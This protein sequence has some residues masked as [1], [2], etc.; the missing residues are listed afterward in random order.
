MKKKRKAPAKVR[1][2]KNN[3]KIE[4]PSQPFHITFPFTL[5]HKEEKK[6]CYFLDEV[7]M[8]KYIERYKLTSKDYKITKTTPKEN[9]E[10]S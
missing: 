7:H 1:P 4:A 3:I 5:L 6:L 8:K 10:N 2:P 9:A